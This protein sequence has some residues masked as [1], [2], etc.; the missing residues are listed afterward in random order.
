MEAAFAE[1][2]FGK[3]CSNL[4]SRSADWSIFVLKLPPELRVE[5]RGMLVEAGRG[6]NALIR[7]GAVKECRS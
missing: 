2:L 7:A 6:G 3:H 4:S 1:I 5:S